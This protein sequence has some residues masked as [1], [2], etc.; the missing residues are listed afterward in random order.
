[1]YHCSD[2]LTDVART[3]LLVLYDETEYIS[4]ANYKGTGNA[5]IYCDYKLSGGNGKLVSLGT[6]T[7]I[8]W[9]VSDGTLVIKGTDG[10]EVK[11]NPGKTWIGY[12]SSNNGGTDT[13]HT[14][15]E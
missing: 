9:T 7:D 8:T 13:N 12:A 6:I 15:T 5:E 2:Y 1:M 3:N 10:S 14:S 11:L 4:K